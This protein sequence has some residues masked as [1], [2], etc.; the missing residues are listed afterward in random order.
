[1]EFEDRLFATEI[2]LMFYG[3]LL[4]T[5]HMELDTGTFMN[6]PLPK[7]LEFLRMNPRVPP[8][9]GSFRF[10]ADSRGASHFQPELVTHK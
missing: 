7:T 9:G 1:M 4:E 2:Q 10:R 5:N 3:F 6:H 8:S